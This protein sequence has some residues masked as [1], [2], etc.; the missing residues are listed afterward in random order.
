MTLKDTS[1]LLAYTRFDY[2]SGGILYLLS[3]L[4]GLAGGVQNANAH[5]V[6]YLMAF[7]ALVVLIATGRRKDPSARYSL[8]WEKIRTFASSSPVVAYALAGYLGLALVIFVPYY[9]YAFARDNGFFKWFM[10]GEVVA[11]AKAIVWPYFLLTSSNDIPRNFDECMIKFSKNTINERSLS[12]IRRSCRAFSSRQ[13]SNYDECI[14]ENM[15]GI[16]NASA[17][18][19]VTRKCNARYR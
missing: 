16:N 11:T 13:D 12:L 19:A 15:Q 7:V 5:L 4:V 3:F 1:F 14:L 8:V 10:F 6:M 2:N 9:N 18:H 17:F